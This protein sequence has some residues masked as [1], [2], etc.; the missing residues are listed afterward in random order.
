MRWGVPGWI[1]IIQS[2]GSSLLPEALLTAPSA[3][4]VGTTWVLGVSLYH[5]PWVCHSLWGCR[6]HL[7]SCGQRSAVCWGLRAS[8]GLSGS[9]RSSPKSVPGCWLGAAPSPGEHGGSRGSGSL[10]RPGCCPAQGLPLL[11]LCWKWG[12]SCPVFAKH[13]LH[14][15]LPSGLSSGQTKKKGRESLCRRQRSVSSKWLCTD[16]RAGP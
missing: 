11:V 12:L 10:Q 4:P 3:V 9:V 6:F 14:Q 5:G 15:P 8:A 7:A 1:A 2:Q 16:V 13:F